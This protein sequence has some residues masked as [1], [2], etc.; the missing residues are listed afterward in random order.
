MKHE[1]EF[2]RQVRSYPDN[3]EYKNISAK[4]IEKGLKL[5]AK[6]AEKTILCSGSYGYGQKISD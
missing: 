2:L 3:K 4:E 6:A 5:S 1:R